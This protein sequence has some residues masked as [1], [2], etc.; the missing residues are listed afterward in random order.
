MFHINLTSVK[1][2]YLKIVCIKNCV[3]IHVE[4]FKLIKLFY[5]NKFQIHKMS[6]LTKSLA[7]TV[8]LSNLRK[9][10]QIAICIPLFSRLWLHNIFILIS[11]SGS[12][13][14]ESFECFIKEFDP[15]RLVKQSSVEILFLICFSS[16]RNS[17]QYCTS[18]TTRSIIQRN[19]CD[20]Q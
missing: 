11:I 7:R 17:T 6:F 5:L 16:D 2:I 14:Y 8:S 4:D 13:F 3:A 18:S 12:G 20:Q 1:L 15:H 10:K 19:S 9:N